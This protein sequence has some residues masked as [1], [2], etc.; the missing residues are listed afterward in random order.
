MPSDTQQ[1]YT[2]SQLNNEVRLLLEDHYFDTWIE[3]EISNLAR[4]GSG[5]L[6]FSLKDDDAQIRC[7]MFRT[8]NRFLRFD[9]KDGLQVLAR[10]RVSLYA[11][12]GD[13]QLIVQSL[14]PAGDGLLRHRFE[15]LKQKLQSEGLFDLSRKKP[16]PP[17]PRCIGIIS[18]ASGAAVRDVLSVLKRRF[19][20]IPVVVYPVAVQG[21]EAPAQIRAAIKL[22]QDRHE[23]D[24]LILTRGG[25]S[26]EDLWAFNDEHLA[27]AIYHCQIPIIAGVGHE[28]D[29]TI[30][31][32]VADVRAATPS[33]A[34]ELVAPSAA[35]LLAS[36]KQTDKSLLKAIRQQLARHQQQLD[37]L[38]KGLRH[39]RQQLEIKAQ[40]LDDL[41]AR[42]IK[43]M[44]NLLSRHN[45]VLLQRKLQL[46]QYE[47]GQQIRVLK[48][49]VQHLQLQL[50][51]QHAVLRQRLQNRLKLLRTR[52]E[53]YNPLSTLDRGYA[54]IA[55]DQG[56]IVRSAEQLKK[57]DH[58]TAI[59]SKGEIKAQVSKVSKQRSA[60]TLNPTGKPSS[61]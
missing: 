38:R 49:R 41:D 23:C 17:L 12:R 30:A 48:I 50:Q 4:P 40:R 16:L 6:Y 20:A 3:G 5:H 35:E 24:V 36:V 44:N 43:A 13:Y 2:V 42:L 28:V 57:G 56:E 31:D 1:I 39:P 52:L 58:F 47:P 25:G 29:F 54:I 60:K 53:A 34:A 15:L 51:Q 14:E 33:A 22:A 21:S 18:S 8:R 59:L 27:H 32:L 10:A 55:S 46:T 45:Q 61:S 7:A 9:L 26:L 37:A 19:P 11:P